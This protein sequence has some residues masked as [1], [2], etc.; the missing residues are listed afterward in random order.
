MFREVTIPETIT[1][2]ELANRMTER[3]GD[4]IKA[5]MNNGI[6]ATIT[7]TIDAETAELLVTEFGTPRSGSPN[8]TSKSALKGDDDDENL[9]PRPPVVTIM[10]HV[11]HGKTSLLD[12]LRATDVAAGEA[13]GITQHIGAYQ[14]EI[15][16]GDRITFP[17]YT[18]P[19]G[20]HGNAF[21]R[22]QCHGHRGAGGRCR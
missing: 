16:S 9:Q 22:R 15:E 7:E 4:V 10:G 1:V 21:A 20:L 6:M 2:Q 12:A 3:A 19:R 14:V 13:G 17:R 8:P 11:D 5:L 18:R